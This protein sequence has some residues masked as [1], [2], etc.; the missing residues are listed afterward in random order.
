MKSKIQIA[1]LALALMA[2]AVPASAGTIT[3]SMGITANVTNSCSAFSVSSMAFA[4]TALSTSPTAYDEAI[5]ISYTCGP[6]TP[7]EIGFSPGAN[8]TGSVSAPA[9]S[10]YSSSTTVKLP[11]E[12]CTSTT[13]ATQ[14]GDIGDASPYAPLSLTT[15]STGGAGTTTVYMVTNPTSSVPTGSYTDTV[16]ATISY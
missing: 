6:S 10:L 5:P 3:S 4:V 11:Y 7:V 12:I 15:S 2:M 13:C 8:N 1:L 9:R 14:I 16:V